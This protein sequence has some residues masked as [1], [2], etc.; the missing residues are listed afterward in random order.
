MAIIKCYLSRVHCP[1]TKKNNNG[2]NIELGKT[3]RLKSLYMMQIN[4]W[5]KQTMC[6]Q[7]KTKHDNE[8]HLQRKRIAYIR[9][10]CNCSPKTIPRNE[11][12]YN[13]TEYTAL[14]NQNR[15]ENTRNTTRH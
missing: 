13:R 7:T 1:F 5:N 8:K 6:Q 4:T 11:Q 14:A 15:E 2:V 10:C 9:N 12:W 3:N